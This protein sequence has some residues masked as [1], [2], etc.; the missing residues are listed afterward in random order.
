MIVNSVQKLL[1]QMIWYYYV[2]VDFKN[3]M[4]NLKCDGLVHIVFLKLIIMDQLNYKILKAK[5]I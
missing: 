5:F 3:S 4:A 2:T 1:I